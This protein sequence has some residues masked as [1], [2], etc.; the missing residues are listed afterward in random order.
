MQ[1]TVSRREG[2]KKTRA[3]THDIDP[4]HTKKGNIMRN[5]SWFFEVNIIN[6]TSD[7]K[8]IINYRSIRNGG[9]SVTMKCANVKRFKRSQNIR[10]NFILTV[11]TF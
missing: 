4:S 9:V 11:L 7:K 6:K 3:E 10:N 8:V 5:R 1:P 2:I